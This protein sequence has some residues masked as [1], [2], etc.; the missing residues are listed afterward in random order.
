MQRLLSIDCLRG[1]AALGVVAHH[2][3]LHNPSAFASGH[4]VTI[5]EEALGMGF[6]GVW[7]FFVISGFCIH[8]R[9]AR[10]LA[11][12]KGGPVEPIDFAG[13]WKRRIV[14]LYPAYLVCLVLYLALNVMSGTMKVDESLIPNF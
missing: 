11:A 3:C 8:L 10:A 7:L 13:F 6:A 9:H 1:L 2:A 5:L 12:A 14:R 4:P